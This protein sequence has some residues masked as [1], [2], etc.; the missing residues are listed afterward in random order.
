VLLKPETYINN[1]GESISAAMSWFK[2]KEDHLIVI[3]D[4]TDIDMG[5]IRVRPNGSA[6]THN[7]MKS[8]LQYTDSDKFPRVRV[9]IGKRPEFMD[10]VKFVLG[11]FDDNDMKNVMKPAFERAAEAVVSIIGEGTDKAMNR[12]N[13]KDGGNSK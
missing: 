11:H 4:D 12:F 8:I 1:S 3:Y 6:G 5:A 2:V 13:G 10:M 7:G 9:G